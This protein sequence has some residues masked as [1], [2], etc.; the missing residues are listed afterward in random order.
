LV[1]QHSVLVNAIAFDD[2]GASQKWRSA[3]KVEMTL[4]AAPRI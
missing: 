2:V 3:R 1:K 4:L